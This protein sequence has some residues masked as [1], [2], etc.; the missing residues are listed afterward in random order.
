M[1][2]SSRHHGKV[3]KMLEVLSPVSIRI[4]IVSNPFLDIY[5]T[6]SLKLQLAL[7]QALMNHEVLCMNLISR[8]V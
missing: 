4:L 6:Q 2:T 8:R 3:T 1:F 5:N 7:S